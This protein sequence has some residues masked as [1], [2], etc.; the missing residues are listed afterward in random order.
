MNKTGL[1]EQA[2]KEVSPIWKAIYKHPFIEEIESGK[3]SKEKLKTFVKQDYIFL[4]AYVRCMALAGYRTSN[5]DDTKWF[6]KLSYVSLASEIPA[7][8]K[9]A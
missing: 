4:T 7:Q 3:L 9:F 5:F 8:L 6:L 2:R 1:A